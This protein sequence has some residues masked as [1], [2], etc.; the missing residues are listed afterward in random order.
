MI[1]VYAATVNWLKL[2]FSIFLSL[3]IAF[4]VAANFVLVYEKYKER[5]K[6]KEATISGGIGAVG[7]LVT[8]VC[9]LCVTGVL[10]LILG[11]FGVTF[12]FA[13]LPLQGI[14]V[15]IFVLAILVFS[16]VKLR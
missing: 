4:F 13:S 10:P 6:C 3:T 2:G 7:G 12:S 5:K 15:Q 9:P 16:Y 8:G 11:L 14:E 1:I